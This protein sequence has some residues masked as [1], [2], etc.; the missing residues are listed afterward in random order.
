MGLTRERVRQLEKHAL[1]QLRDPKRRE[2][3]LAWAS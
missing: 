3:L 1:A 2:P